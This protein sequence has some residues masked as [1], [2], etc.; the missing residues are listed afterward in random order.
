VQA[1]DPDALSRR[2]DAAIGLVR[3]RE[4]DPPLALSYVVWPSPRLAEA[5]AQGARPQP[6]RLA[7]ALE[8][9]AEGT[10][11]A[12]AAEQL[13]LY[14]WLIQ[15]ALRENDLPLRLPV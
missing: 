12:K 1:H 10:G 14:R 4:I 11:Q 6:Q 13:G 3:A 9:V 5:S 8:L 2:I 7:A 15:E